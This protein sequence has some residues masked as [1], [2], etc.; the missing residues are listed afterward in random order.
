YY[1]LASLYNN[2]DIA[3]EDI[4]L[5]RTGL[6]KVVNSLSWSPDIAVPKALEDPAVHQTILRI[7]LRDFDWTPAIW[8][9][10]IAAYPY[11][12][13]PR[14]LIGQIHHIPVLSRRRLH[15]LIEY[16]ILSHTYTL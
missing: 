13:Q 7:D 6:S 8:A 3:A 15:Y 9:R 1:S 5:Y 4:A 16:C 11:G 14:S 12:L 2:P 10:I